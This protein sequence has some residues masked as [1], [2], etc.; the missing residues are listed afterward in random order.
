[1][2]NPLA[3]GQ[4]TFPRCPRR[5]STVVHP[6]T[7]MATARAGATTATWRSTVVRLLSSRLVG[8][9]AEPTSTG[10][11]KATT[12]PRTH[13]AASPKTMP[14]PSMLISVDLTAS[15]P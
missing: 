15:P 1:M 12:L 8:V 11:S 9:A 13:P 5:S 14:N 3:I 10:V 6:M 4:F 2:T 7:A